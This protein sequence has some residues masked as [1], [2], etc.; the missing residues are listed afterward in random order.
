MKTPKTTGDA[1][2]GQL[3]ETDILNGSSTLPAMI[4]IA[5]GKSFQLGEI[6]RTAFSES[7]LTVEAWNALDET[8]RDR[9]LNAVIDAMKTLADYAPGIFEPGLEVTCLV[10][11]NGARIEPGRYEGERLRSLPFA[12]GDEK[13]FADLVKIGAIVM[14]KEDDDTEAN[15]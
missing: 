13:D 1:A 2:E 9:R 6:V 14:D 8:E 4:E 7:G 3:G 15:S 11:H 10:L 5:A 12:H